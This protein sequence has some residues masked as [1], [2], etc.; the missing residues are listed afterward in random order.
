MATKK[1][2]SLVGGVQKLFSAITASGGA[3]SSGEIIAADANGKLDPSFLPAGIGADTVVVP[4]TETLAA[5][6]F[7]NI[8]DAAGT[9]SARKA[10]ATDNTKPAH[11]FVKDAV[12][13]GQNATVYYEGEVTLLSGLTTG[14]KY[15][16][17]TTGGGF[18]A[19]A[20]SA[21]GNVVQYLGTARSTSVLRFEHVISVEIS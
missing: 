12:T 9:P 2:L 10:N 7:V 20:P 14:T 19:V 4:A 21:S 15:Y 17:A 18:T 3:G 8:Y 6:D 5:G 16:L 11:G 13:S 1:F